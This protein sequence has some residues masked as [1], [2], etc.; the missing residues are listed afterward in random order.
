LE[1][2]PVQQNLPIRTVDEST[3]TDH[4][5]WLL[6]LSS[7]LKEASLKRARKRRTRRR[8]HMEGG[9]GGGEGRGGRGRTNINIK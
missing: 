7:V 2:F 3:R 4:Q 9:G 8:R 1:V 6:L 5:L